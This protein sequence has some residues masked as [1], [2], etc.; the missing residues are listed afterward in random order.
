MEVNVPFTAIELGCI[1]NFGVD[2]MAIVVV[3]MLLS[4]RKWDTPF[5]GP[6]KHGNQV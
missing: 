1:T 3:L 4:L 5:F 2:P 6:F